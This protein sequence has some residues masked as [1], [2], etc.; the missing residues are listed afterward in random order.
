MQVVLWLA[1]LFCSSGCAAS[2]TEAPADSGQTA[3]P[4]E[5][6][7]LDLAAEETTFLNAVDTLNSGTEIQSYAVITDDRGIEWQGVAFR[8]GD[9]EGYLL[10]PI[11]GGGSLAVRI[12][13]P[14]DEMSPLT[15]V[16]ALSLIEVEQA[17]APPDAEITFVRATLSNGSWTVAVSV[18]HPDTGWEDYTDGWQVET[19]DGQILTTRILLHPHVGERPFTRSS[20]GFEIPASV[21]EVYVRSHDLI[22]GYS[23]Q[24]LLIPIGEAGSGDRYEVVR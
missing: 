20:S 1:I 16:A 4:V 12:A 3:T 15:N 23:T 9:D 2:P 24:P 8:G 21:T 14:L 6:S 22:S 11:Q 19:P 18:D 10:Q 17:A 7:E 5:V 13:G